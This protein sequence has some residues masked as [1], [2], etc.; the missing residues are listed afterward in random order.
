MTNTVYHMFNEFD[1]GKSGYIKIQD[2]IYVIDQKLPNH[3]IKS[4]DLEILAI[5][6]QPKD[7]NAPAYMMQYEQFFRD[8]ENIE[9]KGLGAT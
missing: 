3:G 5:K 2:F 1:Q 8:Y 4:I 6:Y 7:R 9:K